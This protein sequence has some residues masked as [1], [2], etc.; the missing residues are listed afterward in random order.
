MEKLPIVNPVKPGDTITV[1]GKEW[2]SNIMYFSAKGYINEVQVVEIPFEN[3]YNDH[4]LNRVFEEMNKLGLLPGLEHYPNG[5]SEAF[6][7]YCKR[8]NITLVKSM[9]EVK[10]RKDL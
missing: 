4:Y 3:G 8:N 1:R 5:A 7:Q 9:T 6:W 2:A 10:R